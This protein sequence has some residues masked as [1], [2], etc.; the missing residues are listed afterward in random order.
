MGYEAYLI[1]PVEENGWVPAVNF[2]DGSLSISESG[3]VDQYTLSWAGNINNQ[4]Y[5]GLG[6]NILTLSYTKRTAHQET[7]RINSAELKSL[8]HLSGVGIGGSIGL[9][10]R[11]IQALRIGA[12]F[13]TPTAMSLSV[14]TEGDIYSTV[15]GNKYEVLTPASGVMSENMTS[16][17]RTSIGIAGQL[18]NEGLLSLQYDYAHAAQMEDVY[19]LRIGA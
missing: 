10:Y 11:P 1:N 12:S 4:W 19:T 7:D 13:Q 15:N 18:G 3:S 17:L 6:L 8:Y 2:V 9:I 14:Q 16:P 5:I